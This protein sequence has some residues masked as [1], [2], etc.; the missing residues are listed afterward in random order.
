MDQFVSAISLALALSTM[1][2]FFA[3]GIVFICRWLDWSPVNI[4]VILNN[5]VH[6]DCRPSPT[7]KDER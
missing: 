6:E 2:A 1:G 5:Y 4:K 7:T 3:L